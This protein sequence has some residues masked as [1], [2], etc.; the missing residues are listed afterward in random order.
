MGW[1]STASAERA[2]LELGAVL[3]SLEPARVGR[4]RTER[5][6]RRVKVVEVGWSRCAVDHRST[7]A[8]TLGRPG[9]AVGW[10]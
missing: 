3:V 10:M 8:A 9:T 6:R 1:E 2:A 4:P 7:L 5:V